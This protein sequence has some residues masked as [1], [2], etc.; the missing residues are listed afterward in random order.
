MLKWPS[1]AK[2]AIRRL[3]EPLQDIDVYVEDEGDEAF[4]RCLFRF[5]T[6]DEVRIRR[7]FALN[8]RENVL[9]AALVHDHQSRRALFVVDGDLHWVKCG[10]QP[11]VHGVHCH[12]AYC[13]E[14]LLLCNLGLATLVAQE[15]AILESEA[16]NQLNFELWKERVRRP[17]VEL[18]AAFAVTH[19]FAPSIPTVSRGIGAVITMDPV[20]KIPS[21]DL[22]KVSQLKDIVMDAASLLATR[23]VVEMRYAKILEYIN[24]LNEPIRVVSGKDFLLPLMG[25]HLNALGCRIT[26]KSLRIRLAGSGEKARFATLA[27]ALRGAAIGHLELPP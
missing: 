9:A 11:E 7:V 25:F 18:F 23:D 4:Y 22:N 2:L 16:I 20:T 8:G 13:V 15:K 24:G 3:F 12:Q 17:L 26:R 6:N 14:N 5:A 1:R 19:E 10:M 21:L 27:T